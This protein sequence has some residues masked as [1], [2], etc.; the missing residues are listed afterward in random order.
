MS[1]RDR[2]IIAVR[3]TL[4]RVYGWLPFETPAFMFPL[5]TEERDAIDPSFDPFDL[6]DFFDHAEPD[7]SEAS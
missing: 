6:D 5:T 2:I 1:T 4:I 7:E 3:P